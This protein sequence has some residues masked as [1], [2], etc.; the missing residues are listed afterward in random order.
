MR[1]YLVF[2]TA[3]VLAALAA[4]VALAVI[5]KTLEPVDG[6]LTRIGGYAERDF[7]WN[8]VQ[9]VIEIKASNGSIA[10][11]DV[12]LLGDSFAQRNIWQSVLESKSNITILNYQYAQNPCPNSFIDFA[13][14][15]SSAKTIVIE[16]VE[17]EFLNRFGN[18]LNCQYS[19]LH[20]YPI[21]ATRTVATRRIV[22]AEF[23]IRQ[24]IL[25][26]LNTLRMNWTPD[27][28]IRGRAINAPINSICAK[29]SNRRADRMLYLR[30]DE[31]KLHWKREE[32]AQAISNILHI[33]K[34]FA[35]SGKN[36]V[37]IVVPDKLSVYQGCLLNDPDLEARKQVNITNLLIASGVN[38]PDLLS[39]FQE[40][41]GKIVDLYLPNNTH[42]SESG[43]VVMADY[44]E[45]YVARMR[46]PV[47]GA[48]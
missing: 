47:S 26:A 9:P 8:S 42:L 7:G 12:L 24:T 23:H 37:F 30:E 25:V 27:V 38:T 48:H 19:A 31:D 4:I 22:P 11:P 21:A 18:R 10:D 1:S 34:K 28:A 2:F 15:Q 20:S 43:Y 45:K 35:D 29:F 33:Q 17:R 6:D 39:V 40:N 36:F 16:I 41:A 46:D 5:F 44:L 32:M 14:S 13:L 3:T